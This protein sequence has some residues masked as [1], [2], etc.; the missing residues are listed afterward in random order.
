M[1]TTL[2]SAHAYDFEVDGIYYTITS[3][4][5]LEV[6][7]VKPGSRGDSSAYYKGEISVPSSVNWQNRTYSVVAI[8]PEAFIRRYHSYDDY[9]DSNT[10][11]RLVTIAEGVKTI[12]SHAFDYCT[13]LSAIELPSTIEVIGFSAFHYCPLLQ[14]VNIPN[15]VTVIQEEAFRYCSNLTKIILPGQLSYIEASA[16]AYCSKLAEVF[17]LGET[18][19]TGISSSTLSNVFY[20]CH[21]YIEFY[22]PSA[23][24]YGFGTEYLSGLDNNRFTYTGNSN[25]IKVTNNLGAYDCEIENAETEIDAGSYKKMIK[26]VY[27]NGVDFTVNIPFEYTIAGAPL[28]AQV[29]DAT[30]HYGDA[31]PAFNCR[32]EG[33]VNNESLDSDGISLSYECAATAG[34]PV[35]EYPIR[36]AVN[37]KNYDVTYTYG[38]LTVEKAPLALTTPNVSRVY[39]EN[40]PEF[41]IEYQGLKN[42]ESAP[43]WSSAPTVSTTATRTSAIGDYD[44]VINGGVAPNYE[45]TAAT[46]GKLT[47]TK[48]DAVVKANNYTRV[49]G[50]ENP[51]FECSYAGLIAG[52]SE[53]FLLQLPTIETAA[54]RN[55][56]VGTYEIVAKDAAAKN[57][58]FTYE[59]GVLT[60]VK[61]PQQIT[62]TQTFENVKPG[63]VV[64]LTAKSTS[65]L[66]IE[67]T[68]LKPSVATIELQGDKAYARFIASGEV[69]IKAAQTGDANHE[70]AEDAY[71]NVTVWQN[72]ESLALNEAE[73][74]LAEYDSF[75]LT[76]TV[77]P[78]T[79]T[80]KEIAWSSSDEAV[81]TV[82]GG[83]VRALS[84]GHAIITATTTD[85]TNLSATCNVTVIKPV[86]GIIAE[87]TQIEL[88][89][90]KST[91]IVAAAVPANATNTAL[92]WTSDDET[93]ATV[94]QSGLITAV[95]EGNTRIIIS[96]ADES[97]VEAVCAVT[98]T[99][100]KSGISEVV[101]DSEK[102]SVFTT[103]GRCILRDAT[104]SELSALRHGI[105]ILRYETGRTDKIAIN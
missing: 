104:R 2:F 101:A 78:A 40:N 60:I 49:Y 63:D 68:S 41:D 76:A 105:Y 12:G 77:M 83:I 93:I 69:T 47:V 42:N 92:V 1:L 21:P 102:V 16:F 45:I 89:V 20:N 97:G 27:S 23:K 18:C 17:F 86:A 84:Q 52:E 59:N 26:A 38:K 94:N 15:S 85:G 66:P 100:L 10:E 5:R 75:T 24:N 62:W 3:A 25:E 58:N 35:G 9:Y 80:Q 28:T 81:A 13:S 88:E 56:P 14:V 4:S 96:A 30:R 34:S 54:T 33:F 71:A 37:A 39:G 43:E 46:G 29:D 90:G 57:Y 103:D 64:E 74:K 67:F 22:V 98:V 70:A 79:T 31:N 95:A 50:E 55:S 7:V 19:P 87:P 51:A 11:L 61:A 48:K 73:I 65:G 6:E 32:V 72:A 99:P 36:A 8:A 91:T 82:S 53:N 44:I